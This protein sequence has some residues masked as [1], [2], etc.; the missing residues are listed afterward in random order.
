MGLSDCWKLPA[1]GCW[2]ALSTLNPGEIDKGQ[3][4]WFLGG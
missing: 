1:F 2:L 4:K 3:L